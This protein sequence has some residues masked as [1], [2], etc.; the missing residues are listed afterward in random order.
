MCGI[1]GKTLVCARARA[2]VHFG[3][4]IKIAHHICIH[5]IHACDRGACAHTRES[6]QM[7]SERTRKCVKVAGAQTDTH[8][9]ARLTRFHI[10]QHGAQAHTST[11]QRDY[12][13]KSYG[14]A[15][16]REKR[17]A[18]P[19]VLVITSNIVYY[20]AYTI[21]LCI[22]CKNHR[23]ELSLSRQPKRQRFE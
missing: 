21:C 2:I 23:C 10:R 4:Y 6:Y 17:F 8:T 13:W 22:M 5:I 18:G 15:S 16:V 3:I 1:L 20:I 19:G 9:R 14:R 11:Q 12:G 7:F